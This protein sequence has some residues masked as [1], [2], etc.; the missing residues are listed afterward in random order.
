MP[1]LQTTGSL[2]YQTGYPVAPSS[3]HSSRRVFGR[4]RW[5][6]LSKG[7]STNRITSLSRRASR[8]L[9]N[10]PV[11]IEWLIAVT[12]FIIIII[13]ITVVTEKRWSRKG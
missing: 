3:V 4:R 5:S 6:H 2:L 10:G 7:S 1:G 8:G 13:I 12:A 11:T 9:H